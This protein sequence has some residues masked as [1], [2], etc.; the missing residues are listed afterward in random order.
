[1]LNGKL[2]VNWHSQ[3]PNQRPL[4]NYDWML[5]LIMHTLMLDNEMLRHMSRAILSKIYSFALIM[6]RSQLLIEIP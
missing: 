4:A 3:G 5:E 6:M 2:Y 1:M